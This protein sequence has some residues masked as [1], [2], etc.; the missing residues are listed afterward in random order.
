VTA[1]DAATGEV[2]M[3]CQGS[4]HTRQIIN[5]GNRLIM[6]TGTS[7]VAIHLNPE[8]KES[9]RRSIV[10]ADVET[11]GI[12]WRKE[13]SNETLLPMVVS[14]DALLYQTNEHLVCLNLTSGDEKWRIVHPIHIA[15][16]GSRM[17]QWASP[18]LTAHNGIV[19]VADFRSLSATAKPSGSV[20][21]GKA[22]ALRLIS[23]SSTGCSGA[24]IHRSEDVRI[25][26]KAWMQ[27]PGSWSR[28]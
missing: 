2:L 12:V 17:W 10:A 4:E 19:Y 7:Q 13:V 27:E 8:G 15:K 21:A 1:F 24:G 25:S 22:F 26:A 9:A 16:A 18:T 3:T 11:G 28:P 14:G 5:T 6:L 20:Q 23:L